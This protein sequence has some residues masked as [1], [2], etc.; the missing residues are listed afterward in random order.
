[1]VFDA[2][3]K[4]IKRFGETKEYPNSINTQS[5]AYF[6]S[7][8]FMGRNQFLALLRDYEI[9]NQ[10]NQ[11]K[12]EYLDAGHFEGYWDPHIGKIG[13][14]FI[15]RVTESGLELIKTLIPEHKLVPFDIVDNE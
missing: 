4:G 10:W 15:P 2:L 8:G 1:M 12:Q 3:P 5:A 9:L 7:E 13:R 11:P 14:Q 6:L